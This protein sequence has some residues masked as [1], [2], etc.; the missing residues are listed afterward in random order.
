VKS[1]WIVSHVREFEDGHEDVKHIGVFTSR[2]LAERALEKVKDQPGFRDCPEGFSVDEWRLNQI[3]W[4][5]GYVTIQP[6][7]E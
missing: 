7:D 6:G 3:G 5:E 2:E 1:V 4:S